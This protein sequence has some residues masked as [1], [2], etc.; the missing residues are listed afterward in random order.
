LVDYTIYGQIQKIIIEE[1]RFLKHYQ[2]QVIGNVDP[3]L[4]GRVQVICPEIG[5]STP[6]VCPWCAPRQMHAMSVPAIGEWVEIYF[7]S[8]HPDRPVYLGLDCSVQDSIPSTFDGVPSTHVIFESPNTAKGIVYNEMLDQLD[9]TGT[10]I[11]I[12]GS[13]AIE[14][15][16]LGTALSA[17]L[18]PI[19]GPPPPGVLSLT[20]KV[21]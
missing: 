14:P 12:G 19:A 21:K 20:T 15:M 7:I 1:T 10:L 18:S 6:D 2:A 5:W 9:I 16:V 3:L 13:D 11:N 8:G 17:W 4:R